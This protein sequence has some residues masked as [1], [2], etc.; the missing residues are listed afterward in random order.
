MT[1][2]EK[3]IYNRLKQ[4]EKRARDRGEF[5][6]ANVATATSG[7][8]LVSDKDGVQTWKLNIVPSKKEA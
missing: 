6:E 2:E 8:V 7:P 4:R 3:R 5:V 1:P